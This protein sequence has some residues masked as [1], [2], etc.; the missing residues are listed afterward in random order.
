M[1]QLTS[2]RWLQ[3]ADG[4][5]FCIPNHFAVDALFPNIVGMPRARGYAHVWVVTRGGKKID[6][7]QGPQTIFR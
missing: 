6:T 5:E 3:I 2:Y 1:L 7:G 4:Q